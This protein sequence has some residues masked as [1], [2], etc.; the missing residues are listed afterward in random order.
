MLSA[1]PVIVASEPVRV[2]RI[3]VGGLQRRLDQWM[4][5]RAAGVQ[6]TDMWHLISGR[7]ELRSAE[8]LL[9]PLP[10]FGRLKP[11]KE[12]RGFRRTP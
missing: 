2:Y 7:R 8:Q 9:T 5:L 1:M 3:E 12:L 11:H 4:R 6:D 10:L